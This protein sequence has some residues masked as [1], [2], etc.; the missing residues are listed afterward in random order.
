LFLLLVPNS[1]SRPLLPLLLL[2]VDSPPK[3]MERLC[4]Q[5]LLRV[6][7][8]LPP[9]ARIADP[10]VRVPLRDV[11]NPNEPSRSLAFLVPLRLP[12]MPRPLERSSS[13]PSRDNADASRCSWL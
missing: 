13:P 3:L 7:L 10:A 11:D 6:P 12:P 8:L 5:L 2:P 4:R 1:G 9:P